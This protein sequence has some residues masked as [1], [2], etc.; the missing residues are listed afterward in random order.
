MY[1]FGQKT[2]FSLK[3]DSNLGSLLSLMMKTYSCIFFRKFPE[4]LFSPIGSYEHVD[5]T[6]NCWNYAITTLNLITDND[7][8][9][10]AIRQM[11]KEV[12]HSKAKGDNRCDAHECHMTFEIS[13][14]LT[15]SRYIFY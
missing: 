13:S 14:S 6:A 5:D 15:S 4:E 8:S 2:N 3:Q 12:V 1:F 7:G 9:R 11:G 10:R